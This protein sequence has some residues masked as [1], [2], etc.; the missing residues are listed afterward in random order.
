MI[1]EEQKALEDS[2]LTQIESRIEAAS[3]EGWVVE[4]GGGDWKDRVIFVRGA[5]YS[6]TPGVREFIVRAVDMKKV[7][8]VFVAHA[9]QDVPALLAEV[10]R[11]RSLLSAY[12]NIG[13]GDP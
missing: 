12:T 2:Y 1:A 10:R 8:A 11:L 5:P 13:G 7:D 9:R 6:H 4:Y 3:P